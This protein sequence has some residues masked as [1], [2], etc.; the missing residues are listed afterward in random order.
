MSGKVLRS[1][2]VEQHRHV[3][4]EPIEEIAKLEAF[5][6]VEQKVAHRRPRIG[7]AGRVTDAGVLRLGPPMAS[8]TFLAA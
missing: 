8:T 2:A 6:R 4:P 1:P 5:L 7:T 3:S